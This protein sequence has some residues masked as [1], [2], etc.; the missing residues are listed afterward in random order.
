MRRS[1]RA[2][3]EAC[4]NNAGVDEAKTRTGI[5]VCLRHNAPRLVT[6]R[7]KVDSQNTTTSGATLYS[8]RAGPTDAAS[9]GIQRSKMRVK[10]LKLSLIWMSRAPARILDF[11][12][13]SDILARDSQCSVYRGDI[14]SWRLS[15]RIP[16]AARIASPLI[17]PS[18]TDPPWVRR[19]GV[20]FVHCDGERRRASVPVMPKD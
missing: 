13:K 2:P 10:N 15:A 9:P 17:I 18:W 19:P 6:A 4:S 3:C 8:A 1:L 16:D 14:M 20:L 11:E 12:I 5:P 7:C